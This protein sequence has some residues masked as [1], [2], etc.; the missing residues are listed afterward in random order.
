MPKEKVVRK[1]SYVAGSNPTGAGGGMGQHFLKNIAVVQ[2]IVA[3]AGI[4]PTDVVLEIGPGNGIMTM[5]LLKVAKKVIAV[6]LDPRMVAEVQKRVQGTEYMNHLQIIHGDFLKIELPYFDMCVANIPYQISSGIVFKLL[7]HRPFFR[8][9]VLMFQE[10]F[11]QRLCAKPGDNLY[12]RLSV[13]TQLLAR[14]QQLLKVG[15]NNFNPPPKVESRVARIE[16][17][18]P[19]PTVNFVEWDGMIRLC[20]SRKNKTIGAIFKNKKVIAMLSENYKTFC[21]LNN[22]MEEEKDM[23]EL[24]AKV[25]EE[26][27]FENARSAKLSIDDFLKLLAAFLDKNIHFA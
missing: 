22:I 23:K 5:E 21:S 18:N 16:P 4:K 24:V 27:Q 13:N 19:P 25:L 15:R 11:A 7:A 17:L 12:C 2:N 9:A 6:E 8:A 1:T 3:K 10:E 26:N 20:F 14:T